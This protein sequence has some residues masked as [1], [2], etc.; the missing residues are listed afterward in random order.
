VLSLYIY[1]Y[2]LFDRHRLEVVSLAV[3][4]DN[5]PHYRPQGYRQ[6]RWGCA[7]EFRF[8]TVKLL[9]WRGREDE[10][11]ASDNPFTLALLAHLQAQAVR[12]GEA[13]K[14]VKMHL[15]RLMYRRG[16]TRQRIQQWFRIID[17]LLQP[18][19]ALEQTF[20]QELH[21]YEEGMKMPYI[22]SIERSGIKKGLRR[23]L[24][25]GVARGIKQGER[26]GVQQGVQ[27]GEATV[28][29]RLMRLKY[30][31]PAVEAYRRRIEQAD[32]DTLLR[33]SERLLT[34]DTPEQMLDPGPA[35]DPRPQG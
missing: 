9:D 6:G 27:Q 7:L 21:D 29:L 22:T 15:V 20:Q 30:G 25:R 1:H 16:Y 18:P 17:W 5:V 3:R 33:W 4:A 19:P 28:L 8:P 35:A 12:E 34:A 10:L 31:E 13:R 32:A 2:R 14:A 11:E 26:Q 23:G 24:E